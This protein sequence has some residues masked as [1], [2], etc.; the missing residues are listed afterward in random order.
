M[1]IL[2]VGGMTLPKHEY[3]C[4]VVDFGHETLDFL[5]VYD[6]DA[7]LVSQDHEDS[8]KQIRKNGHKLPLI[9]IVTHSQPSYRADLLDAGADDVIDRTHGMNECIARIKAVRRRYRGGATNILKHGPITLDLKSLRVSVNGTSVHLPRQEFSTLELLMMHPHTVIGYDRIHENLYH[10][11]K[12]GADNSLKVIVSRL[13]TKLK[14]AGG[15][16]DLI[17]NVPRSGYIMRQ[18][19]TVN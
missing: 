10:G 6:Y 5:K 1:M 19:I 12:R 17:T 9:A 3:K 7:V 11:T 15:G 18:L 8:I 4:E 16:Y 2:C 14:E 13:R